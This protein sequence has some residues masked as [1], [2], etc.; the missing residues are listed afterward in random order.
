MILRKATPSDVPA[1]VS[2]LK[3]SLGEG[4]IPKSETY[5]NW[6]HKENPFGASEIL[7]ADE[8]GQLIGVRAFMRW[9]WESA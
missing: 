1:I 5:W 3:L 7:L 9:N 4:L 2:L 6:K 8:E